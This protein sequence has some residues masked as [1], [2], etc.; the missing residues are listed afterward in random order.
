MNRRNLICLSPVFQ[1]LTV[2]I[3]VGIAPCCTAAVEIP[4]YKFVCPFETSADITNWASCGLHTEWID[5]PMTFTERTSISS[6]SCTS[7]PLMHRPLRVK[8]VLPY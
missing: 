2:A 8:T 3:N 5:I 1:E 7:V 6:L 4:M